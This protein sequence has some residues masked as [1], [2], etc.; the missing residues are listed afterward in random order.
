MTPEA[1]ILTIEHWD[2]RK[3]KETGHPEVAVMGMFI[4]VAVFRRGD[5]IIR[6]Q[7]VMKLKIDRERFKK[8]DGYAREILR[9][10]EVIIEEIP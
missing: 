7:N 5:E 1:P 4:D 6:V 9:T 3:A 10:I 2:F 8:D